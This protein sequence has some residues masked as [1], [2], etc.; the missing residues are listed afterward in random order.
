MIVNELNNEIPA[1]CIADSDCSD[2]LLSLFSF[3]P[4]SSLP[5]HVG[6]SRWD[7]HFKDLSKPILFK[8]SSNVNSVR[9]CN[10]NSEA[11]TISY[12][13]HLPRHLCTP[14]SS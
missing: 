10:R 8:I 5:I 1:S 13:E 6:L 14:N 9:R 3:L 2:G 4:F 7:E 12:L 11:R